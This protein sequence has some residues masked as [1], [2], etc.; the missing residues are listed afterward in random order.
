VCRHEP[1]RS[2]GR[3][4]LASLFWPRHPMTMST[5]RPRVVTASLNPSKTNCCFITSVLFGL[6]SKSLALLSTSVV[7]RASTVS[8]A[9]NY[10]YTRRFPD[11]TAR[12][13]PGSSSLL[14]RCDKRW[15]GTATS[16]C[17]LV[18]STCRPHAA[19]RC[20][21]R[22]VPVDQVPMRSYAHVSCSA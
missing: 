3:K 4:R 17:L 9:H 14:S 22:F 19:E 1:T 16:S 5:P 20:P 8:R 6:P 2:H 7:S 18:G 10:L 12:G 13:S 11:L 21:A 15:D